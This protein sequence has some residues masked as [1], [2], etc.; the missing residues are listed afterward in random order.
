MIYL[1]AV[2]EQTLNSLLLLLYSGDPA[3]L[4]SCSLCRLYCTLHAVLDEVFYY[5]SF[6]LYFSIQ[7]AIV[8]LSFIFA[9]SVY[10]SQIW[11]SPWNI[12]NKYTTFDVILWYVEK[13][14]NTP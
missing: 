11:T 10:S 9:H 5:Y 8:K 7:S 6:F 3:R 4:A 1:V 13:Q 12:E 14:C 2:N